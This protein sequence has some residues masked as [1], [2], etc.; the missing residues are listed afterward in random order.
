LG[1][2]AEEVLETGRV[3]ICAVKWKTEKTS[4][5]L[6]GG[7]GVNTEGEGRRQNKET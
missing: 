3:G 6:H 4:K 1:R 2:L 7:W 5:G